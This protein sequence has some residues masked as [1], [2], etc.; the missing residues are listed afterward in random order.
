ML[1]FNAAGLLA[2]PLIINSTVDEL[3]DKFAIDSPGNIRKLLFA[4][5]LDYN[6]KLK[7]TCGN[8]KLKQWV[9]GSFVTL[10]EKPKDIDIVSFIDFM[11]MVE[12]EKELKNLR[13]PLS[14]ANYGLDCYFII[15]YP[16]AHRLKYSYT[17]DVAYW[18]NQFGRT[19]PT[20]RQKSMVK[21]FLEIII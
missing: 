1:Q 11:V 4:N 9:D 7:E 8:I 10:K 21:G 14:K 13:Y 2:P 12:S 20:S 3:E 17:A 18:M 15:E 5:Y 16:E 6:Q 19:K